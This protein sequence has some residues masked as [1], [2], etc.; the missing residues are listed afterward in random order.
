MT[1]VRI[2]APLFWAPYKHRE[3]RVLAAEGLQ[4]KNTCSQRIRYGVNTYKHVC[5]VM[6]W[7]SSVSCIAID[8]MF[9]TES[10]KG[11]RRRNGREELYDFWRHISSPSPV[12]G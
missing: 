4:S 12:A 11:N 7:H 10:R 8:K 9:V 5:M 3:D 2:G 6:N 1:P